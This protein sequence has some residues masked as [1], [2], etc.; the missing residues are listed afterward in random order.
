MAWKDRRNRQ[1]VPE[2]P[3]RIVTP[4]EADLSKQRNLSQ[5][6]FSKPCS[7]PYRIIGRCG[8]EL[9]ESRG[10]RKTPALSGCV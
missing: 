1:A 2:S 5:H 7:T 9:E 10:W 4:P 6:R 8:R 3:E